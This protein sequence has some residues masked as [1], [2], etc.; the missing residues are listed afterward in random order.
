LISQRTSAQGYLWVA[1]LFAILLP[2]QFYF[3]AA[4]AFSTLGYTLHQYLGLGLHGL[5]ALL[6]V[7]ALV[8]RL[9]RPTL[10]WGLLQFILLS[11]QLGLARLQFPKNFIAVEPQF[12]R[13][14]SSGIMQPIHD[15]MGN[16][17]GI[18]ASLHGINALAIV[19]VAVLTIRYARKLSKESVWAGA[20]SSMGGRPAVAA[21]K[22]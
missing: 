8:G 14:L 3:A 6:V 21:G 20:T 10:A 1:Y 17:A 19:A 18:I 2:V 13:D 22:K 11:I 15:A 4:G 16:G 12:V 5:S 9:P 7:I